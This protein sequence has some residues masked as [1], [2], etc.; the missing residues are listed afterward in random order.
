MLTSS[1]DGASLVDSLVAQQALGHC[2]ETLGRRLQHHKA[3]PVLVMETAL[4]ALA[5]TRTWLDP[6][7]VL[8]ALAAVGQEQLEWWER[9]LAED[10]I[11]VDALS[12]AARSELQLLR[13]AATSRNRGIPGRARTLTSDHG[14]LVQAR[15]LPHGLRQWRRRSAG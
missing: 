5:L 8:V 7:T 15:P 3:D 10:E 14:D 6:E 13:R 4:A 12:H 11:Y 2:L 9:E 1:E